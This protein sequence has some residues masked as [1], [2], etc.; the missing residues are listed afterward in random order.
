MKVVQERLGH[1]D[2]RTTMGIYVHSLPDQDSEA[3]ALTGKLLGD[4]LG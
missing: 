4:A 1:S 3:A 2:V